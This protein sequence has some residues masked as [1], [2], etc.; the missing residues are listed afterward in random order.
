MI[1]EI[2]SVFP[3]QKLEGL[4]AIPTC[5][6]SPFDLCAMGPEIEREKDR[7]LKRVSALAIGRST[8]FCSMPFDLSVSRLAAAV[9][10]QFFSLMLHCCT[11]KKM[12][13]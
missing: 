4:L 2:Q 3:D 10:F 13:V 9:F 6:F 5:Q 8:C 12:Y 1:R 11:A 7:L